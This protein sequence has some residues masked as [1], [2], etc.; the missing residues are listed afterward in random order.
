MIAARRC[1]ILMLAFA[2]LWAAEEAVLARLMADSKYSIVQVVWLRFLFH[3]GELLLVFGWRSPSSLWRTRLPGVQLVR[4]ILLVA[5]PVCWVLGLGAG[6]D[7][8][9][10]MAVF[11]LSPLLVLGVVL[12]WRREPVSPF[13]WA[14]T[15]AATVGTAIV[16]APTAPLSWQPLAHSLGMAVAFGG[17]VL[18]TLA[19]RG[20]RIRANLFHAGLG[21]CLALA[22]LM[23]L[24][25]VTPD[26]VDLLL[27]AVVAALGLLGLAALERLVATGPLAPTVPLVCLQLPFAIVLAWAAGADTGWRAWL[28]SAVIAA[29]ALATWRAQAARRADRVSARDKRGWEASR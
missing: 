8:G 19:L 12:A 11:W 13:T 18:L 17:Y 5:M 10:L 14:A 25:W 21:V 7:P 6:G 15:A 1:L 16:L 24:M 26:A 4:S 29:A 3:V 28:G 23:P 2:A 9:S 27:L 20:E 22:P